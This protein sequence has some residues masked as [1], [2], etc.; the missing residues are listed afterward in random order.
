MSARQER[1][2]RADFVRFYPATTRWGDHDSYGHVHNVVFY[3]F[4]DTAISEFLVEQGTL[5]IGDSPV[6]GLIVA[7]NCT[8][9]SSVTFPQRVSVGLRIAHLG[10]S[11]A[12]YELGVFRDDD[13]L[14]C[15]QG[16]VTYVYVERESQ[17]P[18]PIPAAIRNELL[19]LSVC[20]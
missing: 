18:S 15:A 17:R 12:R 2:S 9:F 7:S 14:A 3:S 6:I 20:A 19:C 13:E 4:F 16:E 5:D 11:S 8:Y 10:T 1:P